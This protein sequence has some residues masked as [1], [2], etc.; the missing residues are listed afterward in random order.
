MMPQ[1]QDR[2]ALRSATR[3]DAAFL[4]RLYCETRRGEV[5]AWGWPEAQQEMFLRMQF[6]AQS[7][8]YRA[9]FPD[10]SD[11]IVILDDAPIGRRMVS[12]NPSE[13]RLI[14]LALL[15]D[16][17]NRGIGA[18]LLHP[19]IEECHVSGLPLRLSVLRGNPAIRLYARLG[20]L[21]TGADE[22]YVQ[23]ELGPAGG[24]R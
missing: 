19:L 24:D 18:S 5:S 9:Q 12:R 15:E 13:I 21:A 16:F 23:M 4:A 10:A 14:D 22:L 2:I 6:D 1:V 20:L 3:G 7:R 17:R 11:H 8:C